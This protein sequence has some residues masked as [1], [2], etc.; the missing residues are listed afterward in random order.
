[1]APYRPNYWVVAGLAVV[2]GCL[3]VAFLVTILILWSIAGALVTS[4]MVLVYA[5]IM[6]LLWRIGISRL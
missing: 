6:Y 5:A 4:V 1:M 2:L 3:T